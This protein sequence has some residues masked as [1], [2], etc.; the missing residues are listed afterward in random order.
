MVVEVVVEAAE[1]TV[2][3]R[4][5]WV[6]CWQRPGGREVW[7]FD[8]RRRVGIVYPSP[9]AIPAAY[10][11][12][13][14]LAARVHARGIQWGVRAMGEWLRRPVSFRHVVACPEGEGVLV[15]N[16]LLVARPPLVVL[17]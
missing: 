7:V 16:V 15:G 17:G 8:Q 14:P 13:V 10:T 11:D 4:L 1:V 9:F 12:L 2:A 6:L 5:F 3:G